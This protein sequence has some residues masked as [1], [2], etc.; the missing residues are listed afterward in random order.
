MTDSDS[1]T[2]IFRRHTGT[3]AADVGHEIRRILVSLCMFSSTADLERLTL[4]R[5]ELNACSAA[6]VELMR[7]DTI[8]DAVLAYRALGRRWTSTERLE[9]YAKATFPSSRNDEDQIRHLG[10][11][12]RQRMAALGR[13][14]AA[15]ERAIDVGIEVDDTRDCLALWSRQVQAMELGATRK[16][17]EP[18]PAQQAAPKVARPRLFRRGQPGGASKPDRR[19]G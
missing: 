17:S 7:D 6:L 13:S 12:A 2:T 9:V 10:S 16:A 5:E 1:A 14:I 18:Q 4:V 3:Y 8:A 15:G 19:S 11:S